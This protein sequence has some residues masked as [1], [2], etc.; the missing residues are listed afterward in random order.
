VDFTDAHWDRRPLGAGDIPNAFIPTTPAQ[1]AWNY[2]RRSKKH[3]LPDRYLEQQVHFRAPPK[4]P[5][6]WVSDLQLMLLRELA[7]EPLNFAALQQR[8]GVAHARIVQE[9]TCLYFA[10]A[11]TTSPSKA[12]RTTPRHEPAGPQSSGTD[13]EP[14]MESDRPQPVRDNTAPAS[15]DYRRAVAGGK[16]PAS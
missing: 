12:A 6:Q 8:T 13:F 10:G 3:L 9:M 14:L 7:S 2:A 16:A 5:P 11:I 1:L 15:L 4:V